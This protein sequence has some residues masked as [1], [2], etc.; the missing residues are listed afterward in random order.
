MRMKAY[1]EVR[2]GS[3]WEARAFG[4]VSALALSSSIAHCFRARVRDVR[5]GIGVWL[6]AGIASSCRRS[7]LQSYS[8]SFRFLTSSCPL[9]STS[10]GRITSSTPPDLSNPRARSE[11]E[12]LSLDSQ[13]HPHSQ[14]P[15]SSSRHLRRTV[16]LNLAGLYGG[17][18]QPRN[19]CVK[20]CGSKDALRGKGSVH[21]VHGEDVARAVLLLHR[22]EE[23]GWGRR[24]IVTGEC[25][26]RDANTLP[27][28]RLRS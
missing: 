26:G 18:R 28:F 1:M 15:S 5:D 3:N 21:F 11:E 27:N 25:A 2:G 6:P 13:C 4:I 14:S 8:Y 9:S 24:W 19:F 10:A 22:S 23:K 7:S 12:L 20:V 16:V 17:T